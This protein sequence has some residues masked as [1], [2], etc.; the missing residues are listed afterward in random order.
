MQ[1]LSRPLA[2]GGGGCPTVM[3]TGKSARPAKAMMATQ[4]PESTLGSSTQAQRGTA[5]PTD[6]ARKRRSAHGRMFSETLSVQTCR[7]GRV[8]RCLSSQVCTKRPRIRMTSC[9]LTRVLHL[10]R[11]PREDGVGGGWTS[12]PSVGPGP[13]RSR[14]RRTA[15][16]A[17]TTRGTP[18]RPSSARPAAPRASARGGA[19]WGVAGRRRGGAA[20]GRAP[21][22]GREEVG[23]DVHARA[24]V[25]RKHAC[26]VRPWGAPPAAGSARGRAR[27]RARGGA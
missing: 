26:H 2:S 11:G 4:S 27:G 14:A 17:S 23:K 1:R 22:G 15:R 18:P 24:V 5:R 9:I 3:S 6:V 10:F 8:R 21:V 7:H 19:R 20:V 13:P 12:R 16:R 25:R